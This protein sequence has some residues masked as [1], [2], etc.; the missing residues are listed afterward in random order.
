M[1][2]MISVGEG[3]FF[4]MLD[5]LDGD[6][7]GCRFLVFLFFLTQKFLGSPSMYEQRSDEKDA[8]CNKKE[9]DHQYEIEE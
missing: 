2:V 1:V 4:L 5:L 3:L 9:L 6:V 8:P 7:Y